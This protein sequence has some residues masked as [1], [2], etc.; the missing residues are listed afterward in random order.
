[1]AGETNV[2]DLTQ[3]VGIFNEGNLKLKP[4]KNIFSVKNEDVDHEVGFA[5]SKKG[6]LMKKNMT[7]F[8]ELHEGQTK[9]SEAVD[10]KPGEYQYFCPLNPTPQYTIT[11]E[12]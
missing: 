1:M 12:E 4:G 3:K 9:E 11:V 6:F 8:G 10:L 5:L 7:G 2:I